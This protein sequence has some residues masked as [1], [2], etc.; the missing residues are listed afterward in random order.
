MA[1]NPHDL[2]P[3]AAALLASAPARPPRHTQ[4]V[5]ENRAALRRTAQLFGP[6]TELWSVADETVEGRSDGIPVRVY[7]PG[8]ETALALVFAHGGGWALGDLD[9]HDAL[10]RNLAFLSGCTVVSV[11]YRQPPEH[12]F[13]AAVHDVVDVVQGLLDNTAGLGLDGALVAIG[14]DSAGGNLAAVA[15]Q[16][17]RRHERLVHQLLVMPALDARTEVWP[18]Y[19][20]YGTG[21]PL[22]REDML[23]YLKQYGVQDVDPETPELSP[24]RQRDLTG[25]PPATIITAEA[26]VLRDEAEA[27]AERLREAQVPTSLLRAR[28]MFHTFILFADHLEAAREAQEF[29]ARQLRQAAARSEVEQAPRSARP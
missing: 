17:L 28:G 27:Y 23:W 13:P 11:D 3:E 1:E 21:L 26:D 24:L 20:L 8:R 9:T 10:C 7:R 19:Q 16:Q 4:S 25:L 14:G 18:S 15:A 22:T 12:P 6:G 2:A 5:A 29:A